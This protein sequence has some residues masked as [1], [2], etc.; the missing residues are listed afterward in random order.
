MAPNNHTAE[1]TRPL[2]PSDT[3]RADY[4]I[5]TDRQTDETQEETEHQA[6]KWN[7][8]RINA[9]RVLA[10][11]YSFIVVGA[12]DGSYG[13]LIPYLQKYYDADYAAVSVVF[14]SSFIGYATAAL[15]NHSIHVRFG[16]R[17][18][19]ILG[20][21]MHI[22]A[23]LAVTRHPPY[24][25]LIAIFILAGLGNGVIDASWNAWI[26]AMADSSM[27]MGLLHAFYG[28]GAALAPLIATTLFTKSGWQWYE[29]YYIMALAAAVEFVTSVAAFW[30]A[31]GTVET[32]HTDDEQPQSQQQKSPTVQ[33]LAL[34]ST[35][36]ISAYLFVY[37]GSEVTVGGWLITFLVDLRQ[38]APFAAGIVNFAYWAGITGGRIVLGF[39]TPYLKKQKTAVTVYIIGCIAAQLIFYTVDNFVASAIAVTFLGFFLGPL[40][41]E[42]VI[43]QTK[44][45]PKHLHVAAVG[46]ACALGS[47]GGCTFP[48]ITGAIAKSQGIGVLQPMV[49][50]MLCVC[51]GL[52]LSLPTKP[53]GARRV[54][55]E[56]AV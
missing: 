28:V 23:Y 14:L 40:F 7:E 22:I 54:V 55:N 21:G 1:Q 44:I 4:G 29:F 53:P 52:W 48:F 49:L 16:Q 2:L 47:A 19:A 12:N 56:P 6:E 45:L 51:L 39:L 50:V 10:T 34:P 38:T 42:A 13:A 18:V 8:P 30:N 41:P 35:W 24:P 46:F 31:K 20:C 36:I 5:A 32:A 33:A 17:G 25:V 3:A 26:G 27:L 43:A 9:W 15:F 11:F 37:V